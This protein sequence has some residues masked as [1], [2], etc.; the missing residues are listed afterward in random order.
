MFVIKLT[1]AGKTS[2]LTEN[3]D[4]SIDIEDA[5]RFDDRES[6]DRALIGE[7]ARFLN[8]CIWKLQP[9]DLLRVPVGDLCR[10]SMNF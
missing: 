5:R 3:G 4:Y 2:Y 10:K 8:T 6:T 7:S 9:V 1:R